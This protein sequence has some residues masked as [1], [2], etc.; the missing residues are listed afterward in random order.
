[1]EHFV[2]QHEIQ[3]K[4]MVIFMILNVFHLSA[5]LETNQPSHDLNNRLFDSVV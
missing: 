3:A 2:K 4:F 5:F 1:M